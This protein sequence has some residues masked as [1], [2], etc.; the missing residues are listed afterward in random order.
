MEIDDDNCAWLA[1][2]VESSGWPGRSLVGEEG[3]HAAWLLA[4]HADRH[5]SLQQRCLVLM[6][7]AVA[8]GEASAADLAHLTDRVQLANG[9]EQTYGTQLS[10]RDGRF[11]ACRL[12]DPDTVNERRASVGL[13]S[14]EAQ[15][16]TMLDLYG[17]PTPA[18]LVCPCCRGEIEVWL[19]E[20]GG[21]STV[22][23][24]HCGVA[25]TVRPDPE[26]RC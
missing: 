14:V 23:C 12:R 8:A 18:R 9:M 5:S 1:K 15:V 7:A 25:L 21:R 17:P 11:F 4:Q 16:R 6:E 13:G 10:A 19:P 26:A 2:I 3:A 20:P 22:G 24:A